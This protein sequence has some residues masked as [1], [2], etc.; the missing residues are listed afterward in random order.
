[1]ACELWSTPTTKP[2][3]NCSIF[4]WS[5]YKKGLWWML[6]SGC[7]YETFSWCRAPISANITAK[8]FSQVAHPLEW[9]V[10]NSCAGRNIAVF[11]FPVRNMPFSR[12]KQT[13][14]KN[15]YF[16]NHIWPVATCCQQHVKC[17]RRLDWNS[18]WFLRKWPR[19]KSWFIRRQIIF[20]CTLWNWTSGKPAFN[21]QG[22]PKGCS[23]LP[24][25]ADN[26]PRASQ[27]KR[28]TR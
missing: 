24:E 23:R 14:V 1:M 9:R 18:E 26:L 27:Y 22:H 7:L 2:C 16:Y 25:A 20:W 10:K 4:D 8:V 21:Q 19:F 5:D 15:R 3:R 28:S 11:H 13:P 12:S 6:F 17:D